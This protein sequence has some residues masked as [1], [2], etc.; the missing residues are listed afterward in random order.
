MTLENDTIQIGEQER[1]DMMFTTIAQVKYLNGLLFQ[2]FFS[3]DQYEKMTKLTGVTLRIVEE[4]ILR[5]ITM[6]TICNWLHLYYSN[7]L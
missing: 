1:Q 5:F 7:F 4:N 3:Y 2:S 6:K